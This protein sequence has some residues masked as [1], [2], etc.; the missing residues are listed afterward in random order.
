MKSIFI[1]F[2]SQYAERIEGILENVGVKEFIEVPKAVGGDITGKYFDTQVWPGYYSAIFIFA[3]ND[4]AADEVFNKLK[5]FKEAR[6]AH[7]HINIVRFCVEK[8]G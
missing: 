4:D 3:L 6:E 8:A 2:H 1:S 5:E 7:K